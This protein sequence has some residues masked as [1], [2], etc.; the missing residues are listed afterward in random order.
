MVTISCQ[1]PI[2]LLTEIKRPEQ[3]DSMVWL[4]QTQKHKLEQLNTQID[5]PPV[6]LYLIFGG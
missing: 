1:I 4:D 6:D 5:I 3:I 2:L